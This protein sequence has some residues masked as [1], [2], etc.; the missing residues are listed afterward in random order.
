MKK[1]FAVMVNDFDFLTSSEIELVLRLAPL[2]VNTEKE[3]TSMLFKGFKTKREAAVFVR[4][5]YALMCALNLKPFHDKHL[6]LHL[7]DA[8]ILR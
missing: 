8:D 2:Y 3:S 1:T 5:Y 7:R 4:S 6:Q